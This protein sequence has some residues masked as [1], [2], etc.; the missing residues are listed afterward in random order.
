MFLKLMPKK[1]RKPP[2][3]SRK[4]KMHTE[5]ERAKKQKGRGHIRGIGDRYAA[6]VTF[7]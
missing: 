3:F 1:E 4:A 2:Y 5:Q 6:K 7:G